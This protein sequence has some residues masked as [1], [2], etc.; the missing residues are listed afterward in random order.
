VFGGYCRIK[1]LE[2]FTNYK[3]KNVSKIKM[4]KNTVFN[5]KE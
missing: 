3:V 4:L 5:K 2:F 1:E